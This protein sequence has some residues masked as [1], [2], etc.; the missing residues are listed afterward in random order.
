VLFVAHR[1][2]ILT[3]AMSAFRRVRPTARL[4]RF[5]GAEKDRDADV[6]L[7]LSTLRAAQNRIRKAM[8]S[9][10]NADGAWSFHSEW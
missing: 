8:A 5:T 9:L 4:G 6:V 7:S 10:P 2:E 3:Q 1:D